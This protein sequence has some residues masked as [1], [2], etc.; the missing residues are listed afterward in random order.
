M[1]ISDASG[2]YFPLGHVVHV[3]EPATET[4]V[5]LHGEHIEIELAPVA[6]EKVSRGHTVHSAFPSGL[7][8]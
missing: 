6:V 5:L 4:C 7:A 1:H 2:L 3:V 8:V